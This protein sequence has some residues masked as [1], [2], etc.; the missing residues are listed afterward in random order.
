MSNSEFGI[1]SSDSSY[2]RLSETPKPASSNPVH[3][4]SVT[5]TNYQL[6]VSGSES[7]DEKKKRDIPNPKQIK[8]E[9]ESSLDPGKISQIRYAIEKTIETKSMILDVQKKLNRLKQITDQL[10]NQEQTIDQL[11]KEIRATKLIKEEKLNLLQKRQNWIYLHRFNHKTIQSP[12]TGKPVLTYEAHELQF[13]KEEFAR[14][15]L[16]ISQAVLNP[17]IQGCNESIAHHERQLAELP[18]LN[19][20]RHNPK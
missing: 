11:Y 1:F 13:E 9:K 3:P 16:A 15:V 5:H 4:Q 18:E 17:K 14:E 7:P 20:K 19:P 8:A 6:L 2:Q 10:E 12:E